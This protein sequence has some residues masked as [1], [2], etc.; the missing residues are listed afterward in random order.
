MMESLLQVTFCQFW[1][2]IRCAMTDTRFREGDISNCLA[3]CMVKD[4]NHPDFIH[5][6]ALYVTPD[7]IQLM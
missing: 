3:V 6:I 2:S 1:P 4:N 7:T 5:T